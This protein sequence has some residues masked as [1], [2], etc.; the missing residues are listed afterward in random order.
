M[1][2]VTVVST[3]NRK[4]AME[5]VIIMAVTYWRGTRVRE[6][7]IGIINDALDDDG[8]KTRERETPTVRRLLLLNYYYYYLLRRT[9][10]KTH[11][12]FRIPTVSTTG[13]RRQCSLAVHTRVPGGRGEADWDESTL[14][15]IADENVA[16]DLPARLNRRRGS[17]ARRFGVTDGRKTKRTAQKYAEFSANARPDD[18]TARV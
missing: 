13:L 3:T 6:K 16:H 14:S 4:W 12:T 11:D 5:A 18:N 15:L 10:T 2:D 8:K 9:R 17:T 1:G 7:R